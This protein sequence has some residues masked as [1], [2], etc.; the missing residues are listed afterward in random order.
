M[1]RNFEPSL[2]PGEDGKLHAFFGGD[3]YAGYFQE[4]EYYPN[5][6]LE[7]KADFPGS[8]HS[9]IQ[10]RLIVHQEVVASTGAY[11]H[12]LKTGRKLSK[13]NSNPYQD[14]TGGCR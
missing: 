3:V 9:P 4:G 2:E 6:G 7:I 12:F 14:I 5:T 13:L 1:L 10:V 8:S 11:Q